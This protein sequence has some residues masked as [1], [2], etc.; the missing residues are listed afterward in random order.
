MAVAVEITD[1]DRSRVSAHRVICR[2]TESAVAKAE[3]HTDGVLRVTD[4]RIVVAIAG[5]SRCQIEFPV[6]VKVSGGD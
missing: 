4:M 6:V 2:R 1:E 5:V 3:Q